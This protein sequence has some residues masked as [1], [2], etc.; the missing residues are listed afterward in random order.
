MNKNIKVIF[1]IGMMGAGKTSSG[2]VLAELL[3]W[4]FIDLDEEIERRCGVSIPQIFE[5]EGETGFRKRETQLVEEYLHHQFCVVSTGGGIVT[6]EE[7]RRLL[8]AAPEAAIVYI[9]VSPQVSYERTH[10]SSRPLL[11]TENP[12]KKI[13]D[14]I[15]VRRPLYEMV[16]THQVDSDGKRPHN[17]AQEILK[18]L[19]EKEGLR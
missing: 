11:Q 10:G 4:D 6:R 13:S 3:K 16:M 9:S 2:K 12:L 5:K 19:E 1:L 7:N 8:G 14:L 18:V 15:S 17:L